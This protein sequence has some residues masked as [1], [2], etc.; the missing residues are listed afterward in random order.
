VPDGWDL[1]P[2]KLRF[3]PLCGAPLTRRRAGPDDREQPVCPACGFVFYLSPKLVAGTLPVREGRVLLTRRAIEPSRGLWT[4]PGGYVD[5]GEDVREAARRETLEEVGLAV[6]LERL[7]G[8]YSYPGSPVAVVV[9]TASPPA[10]A[11]PVPC[12]TEVMEIAYFAPGEIPFDA[13]AFPSTR[14]ALR[15][16]TTGFP[17]GV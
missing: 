3:C 11:D 10:G 2:D 17:G 15:D 12:A 5:W 13:L 16:W 6:R 14:D 9:F 4:F 8:L 7:L 1:R